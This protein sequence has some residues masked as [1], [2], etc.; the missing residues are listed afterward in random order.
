MRSGLVGS[1]GNEEGVV[2][3]GVTLCHRYLKT[4][5]CAERAEQPARHDKVYSGALPEGGTT[6]SEKYRK[7]RK[8]VVDTMEEVDV[9]G[10]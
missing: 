8:R 6:E 7:T 2:L 3:A 1:K 5:D 4:T 10:E 9:E